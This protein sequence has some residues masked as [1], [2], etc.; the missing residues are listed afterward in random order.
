MLL[1]V[2]NLSVSFPGS[3]P[4][5]QISFSIEAGKTLGV[6]GESGCG[7]T[8]TARSLMRLLPEGA[9]ATGTLR[10]GGQD[11]LALSPKDM[12]ALRGRE[13]AMIFQDPLT[14]LNPV[15]AVGRQLEE[16]I[17]VHARGV[18]RADLRSRAAEMLAK[19]GLSEPKRYWGQ[20]PHELSGGMRQRVLIAMALAGHPRLLLADEPTTALDVTIQAQILELMARLQS[21]M[22]MA[23]LWIT[24]DLSVVSHLADDVLVMYAGHIVERGSASELFGSPM[25]PYTRALL[26]SVP[27]I[28]AR[29]WEG[30]PGR[31]PREHAPGCRFRDRCPKAT[32]RC[33]EAVPPLE[34][35]RPGHFVRCTEV[36][37]R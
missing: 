4:V 19:V 30:I 2:E 5:E 25:H 3:R 28:G 14:A 23:V 21:E 15:L 12:R 20:Y 10:F 9:V 31:V 26:D 24:H 33:A 13:L 1:E 7:K 8:L 34:E 32:P 36:D 27:A 37:G 22:K 11:L 17:S 16:A 35:K 29:R 18:S 6:V